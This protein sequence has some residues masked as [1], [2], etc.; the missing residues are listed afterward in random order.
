MTSVVCKE[1][2]VLCCLCRTHNNHPVEGVNDG[3][4]YK[5]IS[6]AL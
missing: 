1:Y 5:L 2:D 6:P 4:V 3:F